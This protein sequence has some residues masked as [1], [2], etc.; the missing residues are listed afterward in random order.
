MPAA[1]KSFKKPQRT[2]FMPEKIGFVGVGR[3]GANM[4]RRLKD[5]GETIIAV[6]DRD[7]TAATGLALE[8]GCEVTASPARV[9]ELASIIFTVVSDDAAMRQIFSETCTE[10]LLRHAENRLFVNCATLSPAVHVE[11]EHLVTQHGG[12]SLEACMA[13]SI[14][15]ARQGTLYLMCGG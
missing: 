4:A 15:Q 11:I 12:L 1:F 3:M 10:S 2:R 9:A 8:L 13:S 14:T 5:Q 7:R 6:Y